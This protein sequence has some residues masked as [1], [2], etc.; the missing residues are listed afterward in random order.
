MC[1]IKKMDPP[2]TVLYDGTKDPVRKNSI[3]VTNT[4]WRIADKYRRNTYNTYLENI[5][6]VIVY[7]KVV[8]IYCVESDQYYDHRERKKI[9][10]RILTKDGTHRFNHYGKYP[11]DSLLLP[12]CFMYDRFLFVTRLFGSGLICRQ[13]DT[14][15]RTQLDVGKYSE[16][17][18]IESGTVL[19]I[20][21]WRQL[22]FGSKRSFD[23]ELLEHPKIINIT[24]IPVPVRKYHENF[25]DLVVIF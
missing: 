5:V 15:V 21:A 25:C 16:K 10:L 2:P 19:F 3:Y 22:P 9:R 12:H 23:P 14:G 18:F 13:Y 1:S 11:T 17:E 6:Q 20:K 7:N 4:Y 24:A 8:I